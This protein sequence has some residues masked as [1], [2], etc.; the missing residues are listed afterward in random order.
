M[1]GNDKA[2]AENVMQLHPAK[3]RGQAL[4]KKWGKHVI[5][6]GFCS[7]PSLLLRA[8]HRLGLSPTLLAV[9]LQLCDF[10]W[11]RE[12]KPYPS[13]AV[14]AERLGLSRRQVQRHIAALEAAGLLQ[15]VERRAAHGGKS[16]NAYD[17]SGLVD[18]LKKLEPEFR[19]VE[20]DAKKARRAVS[21]PGYRRNRT[22]E[23]RKPVRP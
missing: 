13:K 9:L 4:E 11:D 16:T 8:Q 7:V 12:R 23:T 19:K 10:W 17:L 6:L 3:K 21:Q 2:A 1:G 20:E 22:G 18:R 5:A 14:L 15:R